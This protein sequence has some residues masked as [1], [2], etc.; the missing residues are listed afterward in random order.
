MKVNE[1][2]FRNPNDKKDCHQTKWQPVSGNRFNYLNIGD[3]IE[4]KEGLF[5]ERYNF[6]KKLFP[7]I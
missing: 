2:Y 1:P 7:E 3:Q 5:L 4:M 6:W